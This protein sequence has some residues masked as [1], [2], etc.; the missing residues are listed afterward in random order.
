MMKRL[1]VV[2]RRC[3][4]TDLYIAPTAPNV[5]ESL[6][7][8]S[9]VLHVSGECVRGVSDDDD[10]TAIVTSG[11]DKSVN[12][13]H[14][15]EG[16]P[17]LPLSLEPSD[18]PILSC[19]TL[20]GQYLLTTS[21]SGKLVMH[22]LLGGEVI[23]ERRDHAKYVVK[24]VCKEEQDEAWVATAAW[25]AK[26]YIYHVQKTAD[27]VPELP[28]P[29]AEV[30]LPTNPESIVFIEH[31][32]IA[33]PVLLT[34]RRDSTFLYYYTLPSDDVSA[35][36]NGTKT[37]EYLG[38]QNLAPHSNAWVAFTPSA[39]AISP[40]DPSLL[41]VAT[42]AVPHMKLIIVRL[43]LPPSKLPGS[44]VAALPEH[45]TQASQ[46]RSE[47]AIQDR[48]DAAILIHCTTLAPQTPYSTPTLS[49]RPDGSGIYVNGDDGVVRGLETTT[50]QIKAT[51]KGGHEAGS[52]IRCLWAGWANGPGSREIIVSGGFDRRLV[53]WEVESGLDI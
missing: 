45:L 28:A 29:V 20:F 8:D 14:T 33:A 47:L 48:E 25:D 53:V 23:A 12:L 44:S 35:T 6:E 22:R 21:M 36:S 40:H 31:P 18:S 10:M 13:L 42:S 7:S 1:R 41:A 39:L 37:L 51:L 26:V 5:V 50:G 27:G 38:R 34:S 17:R 30:K 15:T 49:W 43:L 11:A 9:N 4:K 52:K 3:T 46:A 16:Y 19:H 24:V 2:H 32:E